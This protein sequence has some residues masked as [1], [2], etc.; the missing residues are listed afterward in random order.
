MQQKTM[1]NLISEVST[2]N[3]FVDLR[4]TYNT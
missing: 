2:D 1:P 3:P 4:Y